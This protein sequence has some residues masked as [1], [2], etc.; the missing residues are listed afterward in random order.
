[1]LK[2]LPFLHLKIVIKKNK[3]KKEIKERKKGYKQR[4]DVKLIRL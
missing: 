3:E 1:M 2:V 4:R